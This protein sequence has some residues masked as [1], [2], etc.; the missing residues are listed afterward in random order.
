MLGVQGN[1]MWKGNGCKT[2]S[3]LERAVIFLP[4]KVTV[5]IALEC[6]HTNTKELHSC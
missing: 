3:G 2:L 6:H 4:M 1:T 5:S